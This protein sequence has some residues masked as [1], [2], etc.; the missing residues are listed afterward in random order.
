MTL[1]LK[2]G[3]KYKQER[4]VDEVELASRKAPPARQVGERCDIRS[5]QLV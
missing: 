5:F 3:G 4:T 2:P 1:P